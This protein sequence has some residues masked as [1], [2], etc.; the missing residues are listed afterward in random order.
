MDQAPTECRKSLDQLLEQALAERSREEEQVEVTYELTG[1]Y[2]PEQRGYRLNPEDAA[3]AISSR[4]KEEDEDENEE[5]VGSIHV[6]R[7]VMKN[8]IILAVSIVL[9]F[10][11]FSALQ[12]L[13]SS[14]FP[15]IGLQSLS[16]L[17]FF[18]TFSC[19]YGPIIDQKI[20]IKWTFFIVSSLEALYVLAFHYYHPFAL[21]TCAIFLGLGLGPM[22]RVQKSYLS[23]NISRLSYV[24]QAMRNKIQQRYLRIFFL[25]SKSFY[26][27][28]NLAAAIIME[29]AGGIYSESSSLS[30]FTEATVTVIQ[31]TELCYERLCKNGIYPVESDPDDVIESSTTVPSGATKVFIYVFTP[32]IAIAALIVFIFLEKVEALLEQDPMERSLFHQT[33]R[34]MRLILVDKNVRLALPMLIFIGIEQAFIVGDFTRAYISCALGLQSVSFTMMC[35]GGAHTLGSIGVH[36]FS[37]HFQRPIIMAGGLVCQSGLLMVLWLWTPVKDDAAVFY[38]IAGGWGLCHAIWETLSLSMENNDFIIK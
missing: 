2:A 10:S 19:I 26:F 15:A 7:K 29:Y 37:Q 8:S 35:L 18:A 24:T 21:I 11:G 31:H 32:A 20:G 25:T 38:V 17:Y 13:Q 6:E 30:N 3:A 28:G 16:I 4:N 22:I 36:L 27:W 5:T 33:M 14:L 23:R 34:Q 12:S 1:D 9:C